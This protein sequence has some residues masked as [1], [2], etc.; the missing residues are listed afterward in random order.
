MG[1]TQLRLCGAHRIIMCRVHTHVAH[2]VLTELCLHGANK[3]AIYV[4]FLIK[5]D[6]SGL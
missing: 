4:S 1:H 5:L 6:D 2:V 3:I